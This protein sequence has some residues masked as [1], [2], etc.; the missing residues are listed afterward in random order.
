MAVRYRVN[1]TTPDRATNAA[2]LASLADEGPLNV[3]VAGWL[4]TACTFLPAGTGAG[5]RCVTLKQI[6]FMTLEGYTFSAALRLEMVTFVL[7]P[8]RTARLPRSLD[9]TTRLAQL[10]AA[11]PRTVALVSGEAS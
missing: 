6:D 7:H 2:R 11:P 8:H 9:C 1:W 4:G 10:S 3:P 5:T